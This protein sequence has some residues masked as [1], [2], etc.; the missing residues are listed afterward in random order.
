MIADIEPSVASQKSRNQSQLRM[1]QNL[2][3]SLKVT[4]RLPKMPAIN[5]PNRTMKTRQRNLKMSR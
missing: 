4:M 2:K 3:P 5:L 1:V